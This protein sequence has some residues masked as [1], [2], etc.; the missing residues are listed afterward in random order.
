M[1]VIGA[2]ACQQCQAE[3]NNNCKESKSSGFSPLKKMKVLKKIKKKMGIASRSSSHTHGTNNLPPLLFHNIHGENI[4][5]SRDGTVAKRVESFCKGIVFSSRPVKVN[6][7]VSVKFLEIS[8]NWSGVIR[9][10]FTANDP[11][12]LRYGLPKYACPDLTNKPGYW[13]KALPERFCSQNTIMFYYATSTGD[14]HFGINGE[15]KG[16]FFGGVETRGPIWALIDV[17]GNSTGVEFVDVRH[18]LNNSR[19]NVAPSLPSSETAAV[20]AHSRT[21]EPVDRITYAM[22]QVHIQQVANQNQMANSVSQSQDLN[23]PL[24]RYQPHTMNYQAMPFHRTRGRNVRFCGSCRSV[25]MRTDTEFCQGYVFTARPLQIAER[26][27]VQILSTE[28]MFQGCLGL[29]LTSCDP[30][31]LTTADL[32]DDSNFLLDRPEYWVLSRDFARNLNKGD[33]VSFYI[34]PNGEVQ[35]SQNGGAPLV[36][37]HVDQ[38]LRLWAFFDIYGS[39]QR[40]RLLSGNTATNLSASPLRNSSSQSIVDRRHIP[41]SESIN[42]INFQNEMTRQ[43]N[44]SSRQSLVVRDV[45]VMPIQTRQATQP[46]NGRLCFPQADIQ[47]QPVANGGAVLSVILPP[48]TTISHHGFSNHTTSPLSPV[49]SVIAPVPTTSNA[50][51]SGTMMSSCSAQYIEPINVSDSSTYSTPL[52]WAEQNCAG[53]THTLTAGAECTICYENSID[54][55]LYMCGHMCMC[56]E[57]ALQQWRGKGGGHCPLCRAVIRDV[58][59]TYKS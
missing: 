20:I 14:V 11:T 10:G 43:G 23:L 38:S 42:S 50:L 19:S 55:V 36:V 24:L 56:Y 21:P 8:N 49:S 18:Q 51:S 30:S 13:A 34:A 39:T 33:E 1:G 15:E 41:T 53:T 57:C 17:Y 2:Q 47:V 6:E 44:N 40:I 26:I 16:I 58:I 29:G 31:T 12:S 54:A 3:E 48:S 37:M 7:K 59:R 22:Q 32:P 25:A 27:I 4:R 28:P 52:S 5:I 45:E 46:Q 9:F 35:I